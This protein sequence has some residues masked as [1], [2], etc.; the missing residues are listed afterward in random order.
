MESKKREFN[1]MKS[2][3]NGFVRIVKRMIVEL[4]NINS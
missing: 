2:S 3:K 1:Q 4:K